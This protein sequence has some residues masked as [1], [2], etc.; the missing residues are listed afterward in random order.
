MFP[1]PTFNK[2]TL[3]EKAENLLKTD[4][5]NDCSDPW[6]NY[7]KESEVF[8]KDFQVNVNKSV[9]LCHFGHN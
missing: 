5:T 9:D 1:S 6:L 7:Y 2:Y 4:S 3:G 8:P